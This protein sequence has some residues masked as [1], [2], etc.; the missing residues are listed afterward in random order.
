MLP[1]LGIAGYM[2]YHVQ[3]HGDQRIFAYTVMSVCLAAV[4]AMTIYIYHKEKTT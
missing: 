2:E 4:V 3:R 1:L